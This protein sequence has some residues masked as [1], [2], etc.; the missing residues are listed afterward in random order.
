[1][2]N[3]YP[4]FPTN[5]KWEIAKRMFNRKMRDFNNDGKKTIEFFMDQ[6]ILQEN[7]AKQYPKSAASISA[8]KFHKAATYGINLALGIDK[9]AK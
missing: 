7:L 2:I 6:F 4:K 8:R 3:M 5:C 9:A 1:M